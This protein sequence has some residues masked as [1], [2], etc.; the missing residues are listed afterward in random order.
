MAVSQTDASAAPLRFRIPR[1][2]SP[3]AAATL[4]VMY[5]ASQ[6]QPEPTAPESTADFD[7]AN[8]LMEAAFAPLH[9]QLAASL[10]I[11]TRRETMN[12]VPVVRITPRERRANGRALVYV[13]GGAYVYFSSGTLVGLPALIATATGHEVISIDYT[14]A[15][16]AHWQVVT[17]QVLAVWKELLASGFD[18]CSIG[19]FGDSAGG[20]LAAGVTLKMRDQDLPLPAALWL[21][22]PWSDITGAGDTYETLKDADP[23]LSPKALAWAADAYADAVDQK[24]PYVSPVYGNYTKPFPPTLIQGGT[25]EIFLS[26]FVRQYQVI[27]GGGHE[28][29]LDLYEGMPHVFH[30]IAPDAPESKTAIARAALF[31]DGHLGG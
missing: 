28:A 13:H 5:E 9:Q 14:L 31:F 26:N 15:P 16:R 29:V 23:V 11:T 18:A 22:S 19:L 27:R 1:T 7:S 12:G 17:D 21:V 25:R 3:E 8:Q 30:S 6:Q 20:G 4:N 24:H 10:G 2:V